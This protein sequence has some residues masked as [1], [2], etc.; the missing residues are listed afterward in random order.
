M[1]S[2]F[3]HIE[4]KTGEPI[5]VSGAEIIPVARSVRIQV[6]GFPV[7]LIWN[8]PVAVLAR[9]SDGAEISIPVHDVTRRAE[10]A[11]LGVGLVGSLLI[12]LLL[13]KSMR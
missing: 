12:W 2:S 5:S 3:I 9:T 11:L 8:R 4:T 6:D 13:R 7:G 10:V 1:P